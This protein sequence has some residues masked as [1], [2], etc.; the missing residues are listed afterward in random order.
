MAKKSKKAKIIKFD[1]KDTAAIEKK[2]R[3]QPPWLY[4][5]ENG[6]EHIFIPKLGQY[7]LHKNK[8]MLVNT[9][10][11]ETLYAYD[12]NRGVW[13]VKPQRYINH[14]VQSLLEKTNPKF[15][16]RSNENAAVQYCLSQLSNGE[17]TYENTFGQE[18]KILFNFLDGV[19]DWS[20]MKLR[21]PQPDD[22]LTS[23]ANY[24]LHPASLSIFGEPKPANPTRT[25]Q[26]FKQ[27]FGENAQTMKEFIGYCFYPSYEPIQAIVILKGKGG[28]GKSSFAN[29]L[30]SLIGVNLTSG[31]SLKD[32][33][34]QQEKNFS[35]GE[36]AGKY[37]NVSA[38]LSDTNHKLL[39][40]ATLKA[41]SGNDRI[42]MPVKN[43][44]DRIA[45]SYAKLL[46]LTNEL[47]SFR[48]TS[49]G[50]RRRLFIID[51]H[52]INLT[53]KE[54]KAMK[55][56]LLEER[57]IFVQECIHLAKKAIDKGELTKTPSIRKNVNEWL[58]ENDPIQQFLDE[59]CQI[60]ARSSE[61]KTFIYD[62]YKIWCKE[63]GYFPKAK[64]QFTRALKDK[65]I[66]DKRTT[67]SVGGK[68]EDKNL[69]LGIKYIGWVSP[70]DYSDLTRT[71]N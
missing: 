61:D 67:I 19:Y 38:E 7:I 58:I 1:P 4:E 53:A 45:T 21:R 44:P 18:P 68:K 63:S 51:F 70:K 6:K 47:V 22:Y 3:T 31:V 66:K 29:Y 15:W 5:S 60:D 42:N 13:S 49:K 24:M 33:A 14:L 9:Q 34:S 26:A 48:D 56:Q 28:D 57:G 69:Y 2:P 50:W 59:C 46:I 65:G 20:T 12:Q 43:Q 27:W 16:N 25:D 32:L 40:T 11:K 41:L 54:W 35:L 17:H 30:A 71:F 62:N 52:S 10:G 23:Q 37:L 39:D 64:G 36:L 55:K 8:L